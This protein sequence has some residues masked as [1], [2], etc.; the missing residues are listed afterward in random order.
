MKARNSRPRVI[1]DNCKKEFRIENITEN[2]WVENGIKMREIYFNC[3]H[4]NFRFNAYTG[5]DTTKRR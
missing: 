5:K 2:K 4:C 3:P 1:C